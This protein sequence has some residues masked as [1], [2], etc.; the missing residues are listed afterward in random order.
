MNDRR[1]V[2]TGRVATITAIALLGV[3]SA[4]LLYF[5]FQSEVVPEAGVIPT[6]EGADPSVGTPVPT[7]TPTQ[8]PQRTDPF[9]TARFIEGPSSDRA[10]RAT[11]GSCSGATPVLD[12][13]ND[14]GGTWSAIAL[15]TDAAVR[16]ILDLTY[17]SDEIDLLV[18][19]GVDCAVG[20]LT[21]FTEGQFW[22][23]SAPSGQDSYIDPIGDSSFSLNGVPLPSP[24]PE[25]EQLAQVGSSIT[26]RCADGVAVFSQAN[27]RWEGITPLVTSAVAWA[28][29]DSANVIAAVPDSD[30]CAGLDIR[31]FPVDGSA[32][33]G[34]TRS[35]VPM[36][37]AS[38]DV[39]LGTAGSRL[40]LWTGEEI[41]S[42]IDGGI[43]WELV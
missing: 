2:R 4:T 3:L 29:D 17:T 23:L 9:E 39:A 31:A 28:P 12:A 13:T 41:L 27:E 7:V 30:G 14:G 11:A 37:S 36:N 6:V 20:K 18:R 1:V 10:I 16:E 35:C 40:W 26:V 8:G 22:E 42:S 24:C 21:S 43:V 25:P 34:V 33:N 38:M 32:F 19:H 15:P 5:A